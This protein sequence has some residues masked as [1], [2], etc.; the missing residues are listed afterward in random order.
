MDSN[1]N[2]ILIGSSD[3]NI[4]NIAKSLQVQLPS[5]NIDIRVRTEV[6]HAAA[7]LKPEVLQRELG[8]RALASVP[9][10]PRL[11]VP[12]TAPL[13]AAGNVSTCRGACV[14]DHVSYALLPFATCGANI[15]EGELLCAHCRRNEDPTLAK[16]L[17]MTASE[18]LPILAD[19]LAE[20]NPIRRNIM[21]LRWTSGISGNMP[22]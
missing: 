17:R 22:L 13:S 18:P 14:G 5:E 7:T 12:T 21:N 15:S 19:I 11:L 20:T 1:W 16:V 4:R 8:I 10:P 6:L 2:S 9:S 3:V